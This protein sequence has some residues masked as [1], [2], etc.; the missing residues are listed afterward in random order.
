VGGTGPVNGH[1][2]CPVHGH[3]APAP[4]DPPGEAWAAVLS[5]DGNPRPVAVHGP[6]LS[7][8]V[9]G[10]AVAVMLAARVLP[11]GYRVDIVPYTYSGALP[12]ASA[13]RAAVAPS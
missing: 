6:W 5:Y 7:L 12:L 11:P 3:E 2:T 4:A 13:V 8:E 9:A 1:G 10:E